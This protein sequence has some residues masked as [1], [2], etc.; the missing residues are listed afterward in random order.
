MIAAVVALIKALTAVFVAL[1]AFGVPA[2]PVPLHVAC[3]CESAGQATP[4]G[5]TD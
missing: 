5:A 4:S 3:Y 1:A 2:Q